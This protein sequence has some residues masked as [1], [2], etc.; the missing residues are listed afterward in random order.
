MAT[1][2]SIREIIDALWPLVADRVSDRASAAVDLL[3]DMVRAE[4]E[5]R[6]QD[7]EL[8][9][10]ERVL[11]GDRDLLSR[12]SRAT[13]LGLS[14]Y[15]G[16]RRVASFSTLEAG[17]AADL[18][19]FADAQLVETVLRKGEGF[20]GVLEVDGREHI[21]AARP[22]LAGGKTSDD[23]GPIGMVEAFQD[24]GGLQTAIAAALED[25]AA[26]SQRSATE[27]QAD[28]MEAVM[29]FIDDVA[30]R[31]QLLALN[32]NILAAQ[33]GDHGRAFRVVCRE[34]SSLAE[35]AKGAVAEVRSLTDE[36]GL[37]PDL[38]PEVDAVPSSNDDASDS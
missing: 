29:V 35:Q 30:R 4:G 1:E 22:L 6:R 27:Q 28:R 7:H 10:G 25:R 8:W 23:Y 37:R 17:S 33:A 13:G 26:T 20:R 12:V 18:G 38:P 11:N 19:G 9:A 31:L 3:A 2:L 21:V 5:L 36:M 15:L 14:L 24:T 34:L 16:N 32:G